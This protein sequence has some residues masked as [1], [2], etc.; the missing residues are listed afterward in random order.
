MRLRW[1]SLQHQQGAAET[2]TI[3]KGALGYKEA[4]FVKGT[5]ERLKEL[6]FRTLKTISI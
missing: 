2:S 6:A 5:G 3:I 1:F 4:A